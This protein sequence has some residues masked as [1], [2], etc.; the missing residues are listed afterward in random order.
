MATIPVGAQRAIDTTIG[1]RTIDPNSQQ[2][3]DLLVYAAEQ[4]GYANYWTEDPT[5]SPIAGLPPALNRITWRDD[6]FRGYI[7]G[8]DRAR[9]D[10]LAALALEG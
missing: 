7:T 1:N 4:I 5:R 10:A 2:G 6:I 3:R 9:D 8:F